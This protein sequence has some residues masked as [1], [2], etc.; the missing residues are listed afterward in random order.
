M[1]ATLMRKC[2]EPAAIQHRI[3]PALPV[4]GSFAKPL[5]VRMAEDVCNFCD[6]WHFSRSA[7]SKLVTKTPAISA[8]GSMLGLAT[9]KRMTVTMM[10]TWGRKKS[11]GAHDH[12]DCW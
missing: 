4:V 2:L 9:L 7:T 10:A 5:V 11:R 8:T 3:C 6:V 1:K 12:C